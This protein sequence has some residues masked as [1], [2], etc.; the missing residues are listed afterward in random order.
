MHI[1]W[2]EEK[3]R[4]NKAK[5]R[6]SFETAQY[7]F[8]DPLHVSIQDRH[9]Q[10]EERWQTVGMVAGV[11]LLLVAHTWKFENEEEIRIV[12]ARKSEPPRKEVL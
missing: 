7:V 9:V 8:A 6:I 5:H 4:I 11:L 1:T 3:N 10:G 2:S 12:S